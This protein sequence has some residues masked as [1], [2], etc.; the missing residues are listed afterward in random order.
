MKK[1]YRRFRWKLYCNLSCKLQDLLPQEYDPAVEIAP[2][3]K[4]DMDL[5]T[6]QFRIPRHLTKKLMWSFRAWRED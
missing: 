2:S 4:G 5:V 3:V 1:L 6:I